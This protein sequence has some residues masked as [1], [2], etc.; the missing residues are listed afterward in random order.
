MIENVDVLKQKYPKGTKIKLTA[1][2][3]DIQP[4]QAGMIGTVL[5]V[6]DIGTIHMSWANGRSLG[7]IPGIDSFE[8]V[9]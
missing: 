2:I 6:D 5:Y 3:D 1:D 9:D 4:I 8:I 7:I